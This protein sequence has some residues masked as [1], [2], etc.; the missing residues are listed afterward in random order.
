MASYKYLFGYKT[1]N[2]LNNLEFES[3]LNTQF[4]WVKIS[5]GF[6]KDLELNK[7]PLSKAGYELF[8]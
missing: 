1:E 4:I 5:V 2:L 3:I 6:Y 8:R 7:T